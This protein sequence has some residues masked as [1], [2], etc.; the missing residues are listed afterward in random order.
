MLFEA[1]FSFS[2]FLIDVLT[3]WSDSVRESR[4]DHWR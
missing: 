1:G 3:V 2:R 4:V